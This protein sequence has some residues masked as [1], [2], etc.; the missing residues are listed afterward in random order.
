[1]KQIHFYAL[2]QDL[3][4]VLD[5]VEEQES[6]VYF[7]MGNF[8]ADSYLDQSER[9]FSSRYIPNLGHTKAD[10]TAATA[11][12]LVGKHDTPM[13]IRRVSGRNG[14]RICV[15]QLANPDTIEFKPGGRRQE[16]II[17]AGRFA[18][19]SSTSSSQALMLQYHDAI[20]RSFSKVAAYFVGREALACLQKGERLSIGVTSSPEFDL[21]NAKGA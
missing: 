13:Q 10:S 16:G 5:I 20:K 6:L 12:F 1:M 11:S 19:V 21:V 3:L 18:T 2:K 4:E 8:A 15:D 14:D 7:P 9:F 17:L